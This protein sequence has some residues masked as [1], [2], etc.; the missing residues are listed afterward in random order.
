[1]DIS[2]IVSTPQW[3]ALPTS[4][5]STRCFGIIS[6]SNR[7][8]GHDQ[9]ITNL[10]LSNVWPRFINEWQLETVNQA[11][12]RNQK[13]WVYLSL[14]EY[15]FSVQR[16]KSMFVRCHREIH[17]S[18]GKKLSLDLIPV[19]LFTGI[20]TWEIITNSWNVLVISDVRVINTLPHWER[21]QHDSAGLN[22]CTAIGN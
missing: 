12:S 18:F 1:M 11:F 5:A 8:H 4:R 14:L 9:E 2:S 6:V 20:T 21:K 7:N 13:I 16:Q 10:I 15:G 3:M 19:L 22:P 17:S